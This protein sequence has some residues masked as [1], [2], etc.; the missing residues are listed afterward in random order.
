M[1]GDPNE[2]RTHASRCAE[3]AAETDNPALKRK[4]LDLA[5]QWLKLSADLEAAQA[6]RVAQ[7]SKK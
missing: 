4:F 1:P 2:C 6:F 5:E 3:I 7:P